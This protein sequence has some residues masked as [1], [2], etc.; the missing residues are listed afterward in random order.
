[1]NR[2]IGSFL[3]LLTGVT[4]MRLGMTGEHRLFIRGSMGKWVVFGGIVIIAIS[5]TTLFTPRLARAL[6]N[7]PLG[8]NTDDH[9]DHEDHDDDDDDDDDDDE[10]HDDWN[11]D[12]NEDEDR[13]EDD[14]HYHRGSGY[15]VEYPQNLACE[16][17]AGSHAGHD[18]GTSRLSWLLVVPTALLLLVAP[19][20]LGS[21]SLS[22]TSTITSGSSTANWPT[23]TPSDTPIVMHTAD[24][25]ERAFDVGGVSMK[26]VTVQLT[27][28]VSYVGD[29]EFN[30]VRY[31]IACC[32]ADAVAAQLRVEGDSVGLKRDT[33]V[34]V[35]GVHQPG[36]SNPAIL[37]AAKVTVISA[38][39]DPYE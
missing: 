25:V 30:L 36:T 13:N 35:T 16:H 11:R 14:G 32:A 7:S 29:G 24:F 15:D 3:T 37:N 21:F 20:S 17:P 12:D 33:W 2:S 23:I 27:G 1:M 5:L 31:Q 26:G 39:Q 38:P 19:Q 18:H 10:W 6:S 4:M 8:Y 34:L 28:F 9:E 22:R